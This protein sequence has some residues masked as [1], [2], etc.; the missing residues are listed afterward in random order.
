[1]ENQISDE[2]KKNPSKISRTKVANYISGIVGIVLSVTNLIGVTGIDWFV[3]GVLFLFPV[4]YF[5]ESKGK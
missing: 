2:K 3:I 1:M 5:T 4:L